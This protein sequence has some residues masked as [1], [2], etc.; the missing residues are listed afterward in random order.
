VILV[1]LAILLVHYLSE[2][3]APSPIP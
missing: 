1:Y 3:S 2:P